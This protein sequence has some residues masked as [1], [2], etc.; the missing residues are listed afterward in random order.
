[1]S[2]LTI[3]RIKYMTN[4]LGLILA[5]ED[6]LKI[7]WCLKEYPNISEWVMKYDK[8][9][10]TLWICEELFLINVPG[11]QS[12][13][14]NSSKSERCYTYQSIE[15]KINHLHEQYKK[16]KIDIQNILQTKKLNELKKDFE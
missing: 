4:E 6:E 5:E 1:M 11:F 9:E 7:I 13:Y 2:D 10:N 15:K 14:I 3:D 8:T 16:C 12:K